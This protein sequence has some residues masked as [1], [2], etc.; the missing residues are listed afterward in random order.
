MDIKEVESTLKKL[1]PRSNKKKAKPRTQ[2]QQKGD[3][4]PMPFIYVHTGL[5][6]AHPLY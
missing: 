5:R 4:V 2:M 6:W 1:L 3:I